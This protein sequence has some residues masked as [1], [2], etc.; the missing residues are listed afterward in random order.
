MKI[1]LINPAI[2]TVGYSFMIPRWLYVIA[3]A[4]PTDLVGDPVI[5]DEAIE[6]FNP[7]IVDPGDIVGIGIGSG[8]CLAGYRVLRDVKRKGGTAVVG[9]IHA[10]IFPEEPLE[11]GA[12]AVVTGNG[13]VVWSKVIKDA[14]DRRLQKQY[15]GGRVPGEAMLKA[16]WDL[17]DPSKYMMATVQ[18][19]AG[20]PENCSFCSVWV[21]DGRRPRQRLS[22]KIIE[23]M[24]ELHSLGFRYV[25]FADDNFNPAT[26]GRIAREPSPHKR[27]EL[28]RVREERL[29]F[30]DEYD[31]AVPP[32]IY[33]FTQMTSEVV[34]DEE[35]LS[36][37]YHKMRIRTALIGI[38]SFT[39]EGLRS[40]GK[41][42]NPVGRKMVETIEKV[43]KAGIMVLSSV[44]CGL[45][46]DTTDTIR[47]TC[48][49]LLESGTI[50]ANFSI[51]RVYPGTKDYYSMTSDRKQAAVA[52][53]RPKHQTQMLYDRFWLEP[54][55]P[56]HLIKH[57]HLTSDELLSEH[58]QCWDTFYSFKETWRRTR[59]DPVKSW[60]VIGRLTYILFCAIFKRVYQTHGVAADSV[61]D[62]RGPVTEALIRIGA[63]VYNRWFRKRHSPDQAQL[64]DR[65]PAHG[66]R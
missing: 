57:P 41:E 22:E 18:T 28:E 45:E 51:Y 61:Q 26:L 39:E 35:Y 6:R 43:Q 3:Q 13:D 14:L 54:S 1:I 64:W 16:R 42:W 46:S 58:K 40:A 56:V 66:A 30:F 52:G 4:T 27:R 32:D 36:A 7:D 38:E 25:V 24:N 17:L 11:F 29:R 31:R 10:T 60:P 47:S 8:N 33:A 59:R 5:V 48:K 49:F 23:E 65:L 62:S 9:G 44:I 2:S 34:S 53:Y 15:V 55:R 21:T 19:V 12:D 20:C 63:A 50:L 37:M